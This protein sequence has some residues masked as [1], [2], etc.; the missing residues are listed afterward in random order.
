MGPGF[1]PVGLGILLSICGLAIALSAQPA[2][3]K[4]KRQ[5]QKFN[6]RAWGCIIASI[7]SF[8]ILGQHAG[9]A[10]ATFAIVFIAALGDR[11]N[12]FKSA[13]I[14]AIAATVV[15]TV[16]FWWA[17]KIQLPLFALG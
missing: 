11:D 16:I 5:V 7:A 14:L 6:W 10:P 4:E 8:V 15:C 2:I 3:I 12:T 9:L 17:L 1:F 13:A